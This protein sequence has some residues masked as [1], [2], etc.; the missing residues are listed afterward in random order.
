VLVNPRPI[1]NAGP[2]QTICNRQSFQLNGNGGVAYQWSPAT[3]LNNP[4]IQNPIANSPTQTITYTLHVTDNKGCTSALTDAVTITIRPPVKV[5]AGNDTAAVNGQPLQLTAIDLNNSGLS[6]F[7]WAPVTGLNNP[8]ITNPIAFPPN[9]IRYIITAT[10]PE[11]CIG[12]D[13]IY[14]KV[15]RR[16]DIYVPTAFTPNDDHLND[17]AVAIPVGIKTFRYFTIFNRW[18]Q[19]VFTTS[20][21]R[22]GWDGKLSGQLQSS[23]TFAWIAEGIDYKGT[24][25][26]KKGLVTLIR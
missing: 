19:I 14:V 18:G 20:D 22:K 8:F 4:N 5:F 3:Y 12:R 1:A 7:T 25:I 6:Q 23:A 21:Y 2:D 24:L 15:Y 13:D 26:Q 16:A 17:F 10:T 9:D 11:G